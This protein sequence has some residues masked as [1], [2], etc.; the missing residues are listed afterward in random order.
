[1]STATQTVTGA[2][3]ESLMKGVDD[4]VRQQV[5]DNI[6]FFANDA[7]TAATA[8]KQRS[9]RLRRAYDKLVDWIVSNRL[10]ELTPQAAVF[11]QH[12]GHRRH[13]HCAIGE[14]DQDHQSSADS[15]L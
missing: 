10:N 9:D 13:H 2:Q 5:E 7:D 4:E 8:E 14:R 11:P 3:Y 15:S 12:R 1:M 6:V